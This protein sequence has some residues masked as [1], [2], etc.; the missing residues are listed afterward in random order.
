MKVLPGVGI[1]K[2]KDRLCRTKK[3]AWVKQ[4][5][6]HP[7]HIMTVSIHTS[8]VVKSCLF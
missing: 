1:A 7:R 6:T 4:L 8:L 3:E 2:A 5:S